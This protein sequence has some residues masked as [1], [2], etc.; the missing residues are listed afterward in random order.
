[1]GWSLGFEV[2]ELNFFPDQAKVLRVERSGTRSLKV[3]DFS[4]SP[5]FSSGR[6]WRPWLSPRNGSFSI[7]ARMASRHTEA[8]IEQALVKVFSRG[9]QSVTAVAEELNL[10]HHTL[11]YWM[12]KKTESMPA[13]GKL[14]EKRAQ[15]WTPEEQLSAL[16]ETHGMSA[17]DVQAW[18]RTRGLFAHNLDNWRTAFCANVK[19]PAPSAREVRALKDELAKLKREMGRKDKALA[20]AAALLV[21]QKKFRA[22]WEDED[23]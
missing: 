9:D 18:C 11:R 3:L 6:Y 2:P 1:M 17:E 23:K 21:L 7:E 15:D 12:K 4:R 5:A 22:L 20:E 8:F 13:A 16:Q 14:A 10:S 19:E